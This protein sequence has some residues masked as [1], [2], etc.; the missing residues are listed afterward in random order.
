MTNTNQTATVVTVRIQE[1][2]DKYN[3]CVQKTASAIVELANVVGNAKRSLTKDEFTIFRSAIGAGK[4]KDSYIKKMI[5]ISDA[6][7]RFA[8]MLDKLPANYTTLYTLSS[9]KKDV[10]EQVVADDVISPRMTALTLSK[11]LDKK[12]VKYIEIGLTFKNVKQSEM[13]K[14]FTALTKMCEKYGI[15]YKAKCAQSEEKI[16]TLSDLKLEIL[17]DQITDVEDKDLA[18][19]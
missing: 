4:S 10:F 18:I 9:L 12:K 6:S 19:A 1:F 8:Q 5:C 17:D 16:K 3:L 15:S 14:A 7:A 13:Y 2:A 11:Y